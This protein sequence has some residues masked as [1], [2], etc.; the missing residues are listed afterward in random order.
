MRKENEVCMKYIR[1]EHCKKY[2]KCFKK[3]LEQERTIEKEGGANCVNS[4]MKV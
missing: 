2:E 4:M 3:E 1:C